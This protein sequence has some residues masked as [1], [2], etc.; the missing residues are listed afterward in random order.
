MR[1]TWYI[2]YNLFYYIVKN[3]TVKEYYFIKNMSLTLSFLRENVIEKCDTH[4]QKS[5]LIQSER[6]I[7]KTCSKK[8]PEIIQN[9][10]KKFACYQKD[11]TNPSS[12][13]K[14]QIAAAHKWKGQTSSERQYSEAREKL[15]D[16]AQKRRRATKGLRNLVT[17]KWEIITRR[18]LMI[19][20]D[21]PEFHKSTF[22]RKFWY[23]QLHLKEK[24]EDFSVFIEEEWL[25]ETV[26][27]LRTLDEY[28]A[29]NPTYEEIKIVMEK[30]SDKWIR[31]V[32]RDYLLKIAEG[33]PKD[34]LDL[35]ADTKTWETQRDKTWYWLAFDA[36]YKRLWNFNN[37][38][39]YAMEA[40]RVELCFTEMMRHEDESRIYEYIIEKY[41]P[42]ISSIE[43]ASRIYLKLPVHVQAKLMETINFDEMRWVPTWRRLS[44]CVFR[45]RHNASYDIYE[46]YDEMRQ[47]RH[48]L[49]QIAQS[50][51]R[52]IIQTMNPLEKAKFILRRDTSKGTYLNEV[53][54]QEEIH[55]AAITYL[56][57]PEKYEHPYIKIAIEQL[58]E[59]EKNIYTKKMIV[60]EDIE[61]FHLFV[62]YVRSEDLDAAIT[63]LKK[64]WQTGL[65]RSLERWAI[66]DQT[67]FT[68]CQK[69]WL[70]E[71]VEFI[72]REE[73]TCRYWIK[74]MGV[75]VTQENELELVRE[76]MEK[77]IPHIFFIYFWKTA[78]RWDYWEN[79]HLWD[80]TKEIQD[81]PFYIYVSGLIRE[82]IKERISL[83]SRR[84]EI[85]KKIIN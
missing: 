78:E 62:K 51:W 81:K 9:F 11:K 3:S 10:K 23:W 54:S 4:D 75:Q 60:K 33:K 14:I 6:E 25:R 44:R 12:W 28:L 7:I 13:K 36:E 22:Q 32:L 48:G 31:K 56:E 68:E 55:E 39:N 57:N 73:K 45:D 20:S 35:Y 82:K 63:L 52:V 53:F 1:K 21:F 64:T 72:F 65:L 27:K 15:R 24:E 16:L 84:N 85:T 66:Q 58:S 70:R 17:Q 79:K 40:K 37:W 83:L 80:K 71:S 38:Y 77:V 46:D 41:V 42:L 49:P 43:Q 50:F 76:M 5:A 30:I 2:F 8:A 18:D 34:I 59:E 67:D 47:V 74:D 19:K 69:N 61:S 29:T 26:E